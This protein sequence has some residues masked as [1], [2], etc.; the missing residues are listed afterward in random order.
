MEKQKT[1]YYKSLND[2]VEIDNI[3]PPKIDANYKYVQK[4]WFLKFWEW[5]YYRIIIFP[6]GWFWCRCIKHIKYV[7][8]KKIRKCKTGYFVYGNHTNNLSD[9]FSPSIISSNKKPYLVVNPKNL[10]VPVF[11]SSTRF[12]GA[13][14]LPEGLEAHKN[15]LSA[16][17][18]RLKQKHGIF[19]YPEAKIWPFYTK[20]RPY[21]SKSFRY[22]AKY[23]VP[24]FC[25]TTTYQKNKN[26]KRKI[27]V[28][29]DGPF[30]PDKNLEVKQNQEML[31]E[32]VFKTMN[33][34]A[35][36]SSFETHIYKQ[37]EGD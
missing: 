20:I 22:P 33:E 37:Q 6:I 21:D 13:M 28:Y 7:G 19:I 36:L 4:N 16:M 2:E 5:F 29:V 24:V 25:V 15:F 9:A 31:F 26:G 12:L 30:Y 11:K 34:R 8:A 18:L 23:G 3:V 32:N 17:E 1:Y 10:N 35:K 14:P 27:V